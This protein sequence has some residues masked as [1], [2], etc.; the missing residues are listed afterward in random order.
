MP[1]SAIDYEVTLRK[2]HTLPVPLQGRTAQP[3]P[4]S[5]VA[6]LECQGTNVPK[7]VEAAKERGVPH[8]LR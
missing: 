3:P 8:V 7:H 4:L 5:G 1:A 6:Q 2:A